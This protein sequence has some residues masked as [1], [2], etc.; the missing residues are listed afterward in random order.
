MTHTCKF[1]LGMCLILL[2]QT[3]APCHAAEPATAQAP[4][5]E[6]SA[7]WAVEAL[8]EHVAEHAGRVEPFSV[9]LEALRTGELHD[10]PIGVFDS[11]IGGMTV[12]EALLTLD[13]HHNSTHQPGADGV[14]DL[15]GERFVYLADQ[16]NM[17]YGNYP[18]AGKEDLLR[19]LI[20]KD[21]LLLLGNRYWPDAR[22]S[23]PVFDKPPVKAIVIACNTATA[24]GLDDLRAVLAKWEVPLVVVGVVE[25]GSRSVVERLGDG[26]PAG[27][28]GVL[29][30]VA[31]CASSAYPKAIAQAAGRAGRRVPQVCQQGSVG[32][33]GAIESDPGFIARSESGVAGATAVAYGGPA[34]GNAKA[35]LDPALLEAYGFEMSQV[36]GRADDPA[37]WQLASIENY[38]RYDVATLVENYR[39][40]GGGKPID[41]L[42]LGCTHFPLEAE[43]ISAALARLRTLRDAQGGAPYADLIAEQVTLIDPARATASEL[44]RTL[45]LRR[46]LAAQHREAATAI[47]SGE[48][49]TGETAA[50]A[51]VSFY[52]SVANTACPEAQLTETGG[53][54]TEY[55]YGRLAGRFHLEDTRVAPMRQAVLPTASL[56]A[57][58]AKLPAV[59]ERLRAYQQLLDGP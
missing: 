38:V 58:A 56:S 40:G 2:C 51:D 5:G 46:Q 4:P 10:L 39:R 18:A 41:T 3:A 42:V 44:Y 57:L 9:D 12:L 8:A 14:P 7:G 13:A 30:T 1:A 26:E 33:A 27:A 36:A 6:R 34:V 28:V 16:A 17:P 37:T 48:P 35:P 43:R 50:T 29:A 19:E 15:Q 32:L 20:L 24:F 54:T 52:I 59:A 23:S 55:K 47:E 21:A 49:A 45:A 11:G 22:A 31:T 53:L 25:A